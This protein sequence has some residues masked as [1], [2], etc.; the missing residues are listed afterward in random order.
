MPKENYNQEGIHS[1]TNSFSDCGRFLA[2]VHRIE[3]QDQIGIYAF[4]SSVKQNNTAAIVLVTK[5]PSK[6]NDIANIT[7]HQGHSNIITVDSPLS[8]CFCVY[9]PSGEVL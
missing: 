5:F 3:A 4:S 1:K 9:K 2:V 7:W 8:Y 6:S